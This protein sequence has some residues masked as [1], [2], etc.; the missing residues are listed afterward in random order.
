MRNLLGSRPKFSSNSGF[1]QLKDAFLAFFHITWQTF[2]IWNASMIPRTAAQ[3]WSTKSE[4]GF[5]A[6][7][8]DLIFRRKAVCW[9]IAANS[10]TFVL[11]KRLVGMLHQSRHFTVD[12]TRKGVK[13]CSKIHCIL[14]ACS[15][16]S[17][18][19]VRCLFLSKFWNCSWD[20]ASISRRRQSVFVSN[21][22]IAAM[23]GDKRF[24]RGQ[25]NSR[26]SPK[27]VSVGRRIWIRP[28]FRQPG[29]EKTR[30]YSELRTQVHGQVHCW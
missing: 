29:S 5:S 11:F 3:I 30:R 28:P 9:V 14:V 16:M 10:A 2:N 24:E 17:L 19:V 12:S 20:F 27:S 22:S 13:W 4:H 26:N 1:F 7:W 21:M 23:P 15:G 6:T 25:R 18:H 8:E